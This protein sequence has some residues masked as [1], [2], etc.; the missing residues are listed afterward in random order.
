[1]VGDR[2]IDLGSGR[3]AGVR[4]A[5]LVCALAPEELACDWRLHSFAQMLAL[6]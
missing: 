5:H 6:L 2:E 3:N 1:M 4:T